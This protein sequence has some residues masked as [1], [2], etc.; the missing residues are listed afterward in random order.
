MGDNLWDAL[1]YGGT[2]LGLLISGVMFVAL[3]ITMIVLGL[4]HHQ[5]PPTPL[6]VFDALVFLFMRV[7][8]LQLKVYNLENDAGR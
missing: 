1:K 2:C 7:F 3:S 8:T 6:L 4:W 5:Y